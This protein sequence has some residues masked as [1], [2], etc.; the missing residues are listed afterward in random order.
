MEDKQNVTCDY[1]IINGRKVVRKHVAAIH[2]S[3]KLSLLERK[4]SN[5]LLYHAFP[6]LKNQM[7]HTITIDGMKKL[8]GMTTRNHRVLKEALR[9]LMSTVL[10]WNLLGD[11]VN[12]VDLEGWN[13]SSILSSVSVVKNTISYQYSELIKTLLV[14]PKIYGKVSLTIQSRFRSAYALALYENCSRYR[15]LPNTKNFDIGLL[16]SLLGVEEG[17]YRKFYEFNKRVLNPAVVEI[18]TNSDIRVEPKITK[19]GSKVISIQFKLYERNIKK[20]MG[21]KAPV[22][23]ELETIAKRFQIT[24]EELD[25]L[26]AKHGKQNVKESAQYVMNRP[27]FKSGKVKNTVGY[28]L[29]AVMNNYKEQ[30]SRE[31]KPLDRRRLQA[32]RE[33][34]EN[35]NKLRED[36]ESYVI[37]R[38]IA[39]YLIHDLL[40]E[41]QLIDEYLSISSSQSGNYSALLYEKLGNSKCGLI[42]GLKDGHHNAIAFFQFGFAKYLLKNRHAV[43]ADDCIVFEEF[44]K[45]YN[46]LNVK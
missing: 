1:E 34:E 46:G 26:V 13:A 38:V 11:S 43:I 15:G 9:K 29:S 23:P 21:I 42:K 5:V 4:I 17:K 45:N 3:N 8:L 6:N 19:R 32:D 44:R 35:E 20:R 27:N 33:A 39:S 24:T 41:Q 16:R 10:E 25:K 30:S 40:Q 28:L 22:D 18:N 14:D 12:E 37:K 7:T 2:C 31:V 36:Y